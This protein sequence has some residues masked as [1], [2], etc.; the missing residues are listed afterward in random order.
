M[1]QTKEQT[2]NIS[3]VQADNKIGVSFL[4]HNPYIDELSDQI[5][6]ELSSENEQISP[7]IHRGFYLS[8]S[9]CKTIIKAHN[10]TIYMNT[11]TTGT[12]LVFTLSL[13]ERS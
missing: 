5:I 1:E 12:E 2:I 3:I 13:E 10:G 8:I 11:F 4:F 7:D 9:I 6:R